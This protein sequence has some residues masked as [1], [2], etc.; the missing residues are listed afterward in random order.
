MKLSVII[1]VFKS[2]LIIEELIK[3]LLISLDGLSLSLSYEVILVNDN[4]TDE[5][6]YKIKQLVSKN[7]KI[8]GIALDK[9]YGQHNAVMAGFNYC[10]GD[11]IIT[12]D[13]DLQHPP[14]YIKEIIDQLLKGF[15]VCY[16]NYVNRKHAFWKH[17]VRWIN[18]IISSHLLNKPYKLYLSSFR[19]IS[20]SILI[21]IIKNKKK[22]IYIDSKILELSPKITSIKINHQAR[23]QGESTY[24]FSKLVTLWLNM[25]SDSSLRPL[26]FF[27]FFILI[28]KLILSLKRKTNE[29][30]EQFKIKEK[31]F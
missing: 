4:G 12:M 30:L 24:S 19:G 2:E 14:Q 6:W 5:C 25:A 22:N 3:K 21:Q 11:Y 27:T 7:D 10:S 13:D 1:P 20:R 9:N 16:T 28:F 8:K 23:F 18:N 29:N 31:T 15:D 26:R 17:L